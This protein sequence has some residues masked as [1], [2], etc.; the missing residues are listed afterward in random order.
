[1]GLRDHVRCYDLADSLSGS[2]AGVDSTTNSSHVAT[3]D[4]GH[5]SGVDLLPAD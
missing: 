5:E 1:M 3:H 2:G 4:G